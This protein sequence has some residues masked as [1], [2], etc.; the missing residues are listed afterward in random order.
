MRK[1]LLQLLLIPVIILVSSSVSVSR[2][3]DRSPPGI[4]S[5][6]SFADI[7]DCQV[8]DYQV[9]EAPALVAPA[10]DICHPENR[11][12]IPRPTKVHSVPLLRIRQT[13]TLYRWGEA[14][15]PLSE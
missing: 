1:T 14:D 6:M 12:E 11:W 10:Q 4:E 9:A 7:Q 5:K 2:D 15:H 8:Q 13:N 3:E